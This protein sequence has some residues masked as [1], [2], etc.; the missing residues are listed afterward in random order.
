MLASSWKWVKKSMSESAD[1]RIKRIRYRSWHRGCKETDLILGGFC[2]K[3]AES[4]D[5]EGLTLFEQLLDEE[6]VE[7]WAWLTGA[8]QPENA[9]YAPMIEKLRHFRSYTPA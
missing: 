6:D 3:F 9:A 1:T 2:D 4:L 5:E 7:I 8:E